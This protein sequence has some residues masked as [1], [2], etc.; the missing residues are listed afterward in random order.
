MTI[1]FLPEWHPQSAVLLTWPHQHSSWVSYLPEIEQT[2]IDMAN[3][4]AT[5]QQLLINCYDEQHQQHIQQL[6]NALPAQ[7]V[8]YFIVPTNDTWARDYGPLSVLKNGQLQLVNFAF[9]GWGGKY[10]HDL[11][12]QAV[13]KL[14]QLHAFQYPVTHLTFILEGGGVETDGLGT[15]LATERCLL[16]KTRNPQLNKEQFEQI[17]KPELGI[18][19][20]LWL[21]HGYLEGDDTD[22]HVDMM[23]RFVDPQTICYIHCDDKNDE[24]FAE[25]NALFQELKNLRNQNGNPYRLI[26]LPFPKA[27][28]DDEG[29][30][31]PLSYANFLIINHAILMPIYN[32]TADQTAIAQIKTCF[33]NR[34]IIPIDASILIQQYG[35]IHCATMQIAAL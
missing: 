13:S 27:R 20:F 34:E 24:H 29:K 9:N 2:Y 11:D 15:L 4:I 3:A 26:P 30:R 12:H 21:K 25:L 35:S 22:G 5:H 33:P 1:Q 18:K 31:L 14:E 8:R 16:A 19:H 23:A 32:D 6:L 10:A 7:N 17:L 28:I